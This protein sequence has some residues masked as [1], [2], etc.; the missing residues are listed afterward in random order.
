MKRSKYLLLALSAITGIGIFKY[1][2]TCSAELYDSLHFRGTPVDFGEPP[3]RYLDYAFEESYRP[4]TKYIGNPAK[5]YGEWERA[6]EERRQRFEHLLS[7]ARLAEHSDMSKAVGLYRSINREGLGHAEFA[8]RRVAILSD[9][10]AS[11]DQRGLKELLDATWIG[12]SAGT[13]PE[14]ADSA[15]F[16]KAHVSYEKACRGNDPVA[17][18]KCARDFPSSSIAENALIMAVRMRLGEKR[19]SSGNDFGVAQSDLSILSSQ[20]PKTR[21]KREVIGWQGR[22]HFLKREYDQALACYQ[23]QEPISFSKEAKLNTIDS[24][25]MCYEAAGRQDH[26]AATYLQRYDA[27]T[28]VEEVMLCVRRLPVAISKLSTKQAASLAS[29]ISADPLLAKAYLEIRLEHNQTTRKERSDIIR[30]ASR[31][32]M[33]S[34]APDKAAVLARMARASY[35]DAQI[36]KCRE[37]AVAARGGAS[38]SSEDWALAQYLIASSDIRSNRIEAGLREYKRLLDTNRGSYLALGT[39]EA[40]AYQCDRTGRLEAALDQ[41][42]ALGYRNDVAYLVDAKMTPAQ[43]ESYIRHHPGSANNTRLRYALGFRYLRK[44]DLFRA[45]QCF[46]SVPHKERERLLAR[47]KSLIGDEEGAPLQDPVRTCND[48]I[49]LRSKIASAGSDDNKASAIYKLASY[50]YERRP[51]TLY[52]ADLWQGSRS[53]SISL[54]WNKAIETPEDKRKLRLHH[55]EHEG[56]QHAYDLCQQIL[57]HYPHSKVAAQAAYRGS[58]AAE[59]LSNFNGWWREEADR[60]GL[61]DKAIAGLTLVIKKY[62]TSPLKASAEKYLEAYEEEK[63]DKRNNKMY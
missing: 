27:T 44:D 1:A 51:F 6:E 50:Y 28:D 15:E 12:G 3:K 2:Q 18:E 54:D 35:M 29:M 57:K 26:V 45:K 9:A 8:R 24:K 14:S 20:Y 60:A 7:S 36:S 53:W 32:L 63:E 42:F 47:A 25:L 61:V 17:F 43:I 55:Y 62:P 38:P 4:G 11:K 31:S 21:F 39:R 34:N 33:R 19:S 30:I 40:I 22:I 10:L 5:D 52:N 37:L 16:V 46:L 13:L 41:Y 48:L 56:L 59:R 23:K 58:C 49:G